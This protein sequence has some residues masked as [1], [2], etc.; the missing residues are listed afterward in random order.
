L[1][2]HRY[3]RPY[4]RLT[5]KQERPRDYVDQPKTLG[6]HLLKRRVELGL[7]QKQV[8]LRLLAKADT[9]FLWE[10][11]YRQ[12][13]I[14]NWPA[15]IRFLGYDPFPAPATWSERVAAKRRAL[16]LTIEDAAKLAGV[17]PGTFGRWERRTGN[18]PVK[19][20]ERFLASD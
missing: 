19:A 6:E 20:A 10:K 2:W 1:P 12:P 5:L 11:G 3:L 9:Y 15:I 18:S 16:G 7:F 13:T 4:V 8:A 17:D 14:R